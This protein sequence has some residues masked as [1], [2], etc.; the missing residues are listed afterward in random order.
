[1]KQNPD[2][3]P[4][5][6]PVDADVLQVAA[7]LCFNLPTGFLGIPAF[8]DAGDER[9]NLAPIAHHERVREIQPPRV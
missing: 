9:R 5:E 4:Y 1:M 8:H 3:A 7:N 2:D 6:C